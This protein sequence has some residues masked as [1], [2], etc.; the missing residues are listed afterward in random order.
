LTL[1]SSPSFR[2]DLEAIAA[3]CSDTSA[4][5][6]FLQRRRA[7]PQVGRRLTI[8]ALQSMLAERS[9]LTSV[10]A[11]LDVVALACAS[12]LKVV[13]FQPFASWVQYYH[14]YLSMSAL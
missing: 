4:L 7:E 2:L 1:L 8:S 3:S 13:G 12:A 11:A 9:P 10:A 5:V 6:G 14:E